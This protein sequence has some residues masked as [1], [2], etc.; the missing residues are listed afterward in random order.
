MSEKILEAFRE[1]E[2]FNIFELMLRL[3][4]DKGSLKEALSTLV[5]QGKLRI[6]E[7]RFPRSD[8]SPAYKG[9]SSRG[10]IKGFSGE[11]YMMN[12]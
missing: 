2:K 10:S 1:K 7:R 8:G 5:D 3:R 6:A 9:L 12:E 4:V 11:I